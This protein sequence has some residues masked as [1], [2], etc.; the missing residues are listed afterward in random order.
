MI[1]GERL[2]LDPASIT[3]RVVY[4]IVYFSPIEVGDERYSNQ[5]YFET[6]IYAR[7]WPTSMMEKLS[8]QID[9]LRHVELG[10]H[11]FDSAFKK[12]HREAVMFHC[13][14][15]LAYL[16]SREARIAMKLAEAGTQATRTIEPTITGDPE[17]NFDFLRITTLSV[18]ACAARRIKFYQKALEALSEAKEICLQADESGPGHGKV[19][20][21]LTALTLLNLSAVLGD[22]EEYGHG[23]RYGLEALT[24]LYRYCPAGALPEVAQAYFLVIACHNSALLHVK[25]G[26]MSDAVDLVKEGVERSKALP[27]EH[28]DLRK[29]LI[30]IGAQAKNVPEGFLT[31]AVNAANGWGE[32]RNVWN[33]SFWDFSVAET[34]EVI[35]VLQLTQ[36]LKHLAADTAEPQEEGGSSKLADDDTLLRLVLAVVQCQSLETF[37]IASIDFDPK[38][39]WRRLT[40]RSFLE[41]AWYSATINYAL[42]QEV[43][44]RPE[45][46][47]YARLLQNST[48]FAKKLAIFLIVLGNESE[49]VDLSENNLDSRSMSALVKALR[50]H[51]RPELS[52]PVSSVVLRANELDVAAASELVGVWAPNEGGLPP[53]VTSL[54]V[55][56]NTGIGDD[57]FAKLLSGIMHYDQFKVL[58]ADSIGLGGVGCIAASDF[59]SSPSLEMLWLSNNDLGS[60]GA[61]AIMK[62]AFRC[63]NLQTLA[64]DNCGINTREAAV[65]AGDLVRAHGCLKML[66]MQ[67][68]RL[69]SEGAI[70]FCKRAAESKSIASVNLSYN[71]IVSAEA[72]KAIAEMMAG[73]ASL[74]EVHLSGNKVDLEGSVHIG[75][76]LEH[77]RV[78]QLYLEDMGFTHECIHD[79]LHHGAA[80]TQD[81]QVMI[82]SSNPIGDEGF[83]IISE[84]LSIGLTDLSL[85][86]C[87]LT[88]SSSDTLLT[89]VSLSP[90][91]RS[92]DLSCNQLGPNGCAEMVEWMM[93]QHKDSFALR[94][95]EL[96][97]TGLGDEGFLRLVPILSSLNHLG[98]SGNAITSA[99][100][101]AVMNSNQMIQLKTLNL[102]NNAIGEPGLHALTERFQQEHKRLVWNPKQLTSTIDTVILTGNPISASLATSTEVFLK[103]HNPLL[104]VVW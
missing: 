102:A 4:D 16:D 5:M 24:L 15:A 48:Y 21:L 28:A 95:L 56:H 37:T 66:S 11:P 27:E 40:K 23:L 9:Q 70:E 78:L 97:T 8:A 96:S 103:I 88:S 46:A 13:K 14:M 69:E 98:V 2:K 25:L 90:S 49:G 101:E 18:L 104:A 81:L 6:D 79:F 41:T 77:S 57:G 44:P 71:D 65:A 35:D 73:C 39:V 68:N 20:P 83:H 74:R 31:E 7:Q 89:V 52:K 42:L 91:L 30:A 92:L 82:L 43:A 34:L 61:E 100:L 86:N 54:D 45:V 62:A 51:Q 19:H 64:M 3:D 50:W 59:F 32:E 10:I 1:R 60:A 63:P 93:T 75:R 67:K 58:Q 38:K 53:S 76:A 55:S 22:I 29:N 84:S 47:T 80:E 12:R 26:N 94:Y 99:G 87:G 33:L 36:T 17:A 85:S 72:C